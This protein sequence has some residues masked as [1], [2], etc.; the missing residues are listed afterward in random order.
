M[1]VF[2]CYTLGQTFFLVTC[3]WVWGT[4]WFLVGGGMPSSRLPPSVWQV[5]YEGVGKWWLVCMLRQRGRNQCH[6]Y[7]ADLPQWGRP[8][9]WVLD[10]LN[11]GSARASWGS[12]AALTLTDW[13]R[14]LQ[15]RVTLESGHMLV[16]HPDH[17]EEADGCCHFSYSDPHILGWSLV[18]P[19]LRAFL[20]FNKVV[21]FTTSLLPACLFG[22][23]R[24]I[25][26]L[27]N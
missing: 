14:W 4:F 20:W 9:Y 10:L 19:P 23:A 26:L 17:L 15:T 27:V 24:V 6:S 22:H 25:G 16:G 5:I 18:E 2:T 12:H 21:R 3:S 7:I 13:Q 8:F 1:I 11:F